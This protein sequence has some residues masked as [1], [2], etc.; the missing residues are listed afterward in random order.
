MDLN[1]PV[2][3]SYLGVWQ[4]VSLEA[5][6]K[7]VDTTTEAYWIQTA[8]LF[9][10]MRVPGGRPDFSGKTSLAEC[11]D[12]ELLWFSRQQGFA[13]MAMAGGDL[14]HRRRQ[15]D[16]QP[17]RGRDNTHRMRF[18]DELLVEENLTGTVREKWRCLTGPEHGVISLRLLEEAG[19]GGR[20]STRKGYLLV[21]D[22][23][24]LFVRDRIEFTRQAASLE[25]LFEAQD[26]GH[27]EQASLLDCEFSFGRRQG[28]AQP[29]EIQLST[30]P[31]REGKIL[32]AAGQF[33]A[34][35][36][37]GE[38]LIQR[39]MGRNGPVT[40]RWSVHEWT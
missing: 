22:D 24:F 10:D 20:I 26:L 30:L 8:E 18:E 12:L 29:W 6:G 36:Q 13:G 40:R 25:D 3:Q 11:S 4:R 2:P 31:Y 23:Y 34:F 14:L 27:D 19:P 32:F 35:R 28:G 9:A 7:P 17:S 33:E 37:G 38:A 39:G 15:V 16:Y 1:D 5:R 21:M